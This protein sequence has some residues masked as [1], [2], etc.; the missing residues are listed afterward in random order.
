MKLKK[1]QI[2]LIIIVVVGVLGSLMGGSDDSS[3]PKKEGETTQEEKTIEEKTYKMKETVKVGDVEYVVSSQKVD[4]KVGDKYL[5]HKAQDTYLIIDISIKNLGNEELT[6]SNSFFTLLNGE[7]E[8]KTDSDGSI[9][10]GED[11][12]IYKDVNPDVTLKG[13]II[14]DVPEAIANSKDNVLKVQ[15]GVWGTETE[16][17]A[18]K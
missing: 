14:F 2:V 4:K 12:M 9:Y 13:K 5:N 15:T 10:L 16:N 18:L 11:S 6:V 17:I 8:Y 3:Q 7:K 1:W